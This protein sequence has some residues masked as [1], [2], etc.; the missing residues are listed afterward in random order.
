M[1][2]NKSP[3]PITTQTSNMVNI[4]IPHKPANNSSKPKNKVKNVFINC[5]LEYKYTKNNHNAQITKN[6]F[7]FSMRVSIISNRIIT[8]TP[9]PKG[10]N[11]THIK[12]LFKNIESS[13]VE[14]II[15]ITKP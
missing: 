2:I 12:E 10:S 11:A 9:S 4:N 7:D 6:Y 3:T 5:I 8:T 13:D 14:D 15:P 1:C